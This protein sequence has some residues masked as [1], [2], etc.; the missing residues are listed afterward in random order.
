MFL[1]QKLFLMIIS[2]TSITLADIQ[3]NYEHQSNSNSRYSTLPQYKIIPHQNRRSRRSDPISPKFSESAIPAHDMIKKSPL[4]DT[5]HP[6]I[7]SL[8]PEHEPMD[9]NDK[10][11]E[12]RQIRNDMMMPVYDPYSSMSFPVNYLYYNPDEMQQ[13][14]ESSYY[15]YP[16]RAE[17]MTRASQGNELRYRTQ[18]NLHHLPN[19]PSIRSNPP[20]E[21]ASDNYHNK[22]RGALF[23]PNLQKNLIY[24]LRDRT[25]D[26]CIYNLIEDISSYFK[27]E[28]E[29]QGMQGMQ[30]LQGVQ[31]YI[32]RFRK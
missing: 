17:L 29:Y 31:G 5:K 11:L 6:T 20:M 26:R 32:Q 1:Y 2:L 4:T 12:N 13:V 21:T 30:G 28:Q 9:T 15:L 18:D 22:Y 7:D 14:Q 8:L 19:K 16:E 10:R 3:L 23:G 24:Y 25:Y 27:G